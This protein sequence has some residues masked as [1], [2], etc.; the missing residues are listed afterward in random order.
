[1]LESFSTTL[2][3][4]ISTKVSTATSQNVHT[5]LSAQDV[6]LTSFCSGE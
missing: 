2:A 6:Y 3:A 5:S 1:M 4:D